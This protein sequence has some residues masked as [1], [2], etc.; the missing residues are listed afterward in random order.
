MADM[1]Y[2]SVSLL[3]L[4]KIL[5]TLYHYQ[6][7]TSTVCVGRGGSGQEVEGGGAQRRGSILTE[8]LD[9]DLVPETS[10]NILSDIRGLL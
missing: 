1:P 8:R 4:W 9:L 6:F 2:S 5:W 10:E 3:T 7:S